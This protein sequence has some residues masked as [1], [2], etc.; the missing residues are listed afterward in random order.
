MEAQILAFLG[1]R[2][3]LPLSDLI[4]HDEEED[5]S[6]GS[7]LDDDDSEDEPPP[8]PA[9]ARAAKNAPLSPVHS[10]APTRTTERIEPSAAAAEV[11]TSMRLDFAV[12]GHVK[13][14]GLLT[15][16]ELKGLQVILAGRPPASAPISACGVRFVP[17][18][19]ARRLPGLSAG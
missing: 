3:T 8:P 5:A 7:F 1:D 16:A 4:V 18:H 2:A 11:S 12:E 10:R 13:L 19:A 14:P 17:L 15:G 6:D 9:P